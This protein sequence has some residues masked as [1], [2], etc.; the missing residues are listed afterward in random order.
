MSCAEA[1]PLLADLARGG[2]LPAE[3]LSRVEE[4]AAG[5][6]ACAARVEEERVLGAALRRLADADEGASAPAWIEARLRRSLREAHPRP[7]PAAVAPGP[8][9][10]GWATAAAVA[11]SLAAGA[12]LW[13]RE[14]APPPPAALEWAREAVDDEEAFLPV[15][16]D[17]VLGG[18]DAVQVVRMR[19]PRSAIG[20]MGLAVPDEPGQGPV[21]ADVLV[22]QDGLPRAIRLVSLAAGE[23]AGDSGE[24]T[25]RGG[26]R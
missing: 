10:W 26:L 18:L 22:G 12:L 15:T 24:N 9:R 25:R 16:F 20:R 19:L 2:V 23:P 5:C 4:H 13:H 6:A 7:V 3:V 14:P 21:D 17:D 8:D 1:R 11:A